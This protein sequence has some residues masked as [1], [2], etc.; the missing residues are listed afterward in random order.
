VDERFPG[1]SGVHTQNNMC[2]MIFGLLRGGRDVTRVLGETVAMGLDND[3][4]AASAGS[5]VGALVGA[6][7]VPEKW[8]KP[9]EGRVGSYLNGFPEF[10]IEDLVR[11]FLK[12]RLALP[13]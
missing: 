2:L 7:Q 1:M 5:I 4:T 3:C 10:E 13:Q 11:R 12:Q 6:S 8:Y 9:F